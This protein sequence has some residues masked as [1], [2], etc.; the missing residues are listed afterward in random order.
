M[1]SLKNRVNPSSLEGYAFCVS[2]TSTAMLSLAKSG[3]SL[4]SDKKKTK[5]NL[6]KRKID[7]L[8]IETRVY[9]YTLH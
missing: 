5:T 8:I 7:R 3:K 6:H 1:I 4:V 2:Y 9:Y